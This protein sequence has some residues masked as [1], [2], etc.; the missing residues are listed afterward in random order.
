MFTTHNSHNWIINKIHRK[1]IKF[2]FLII[3]I[4]T[5]HYMAPFAWEWIGGNTHIFRPQQPDVQ[6][7]FKD[8]ETIHFKKTW[9][10]F[11]C[12]V[13][14]WHWSRGVQLKRRWKLQ[15]KYYLW[16]FTLHWNVSQYDKVSHYKPLNRLNP[17]NINQS[18]HFHYEIDGIWDI[19][20]QDLR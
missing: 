2:H 18:W 16:N 11:C 7:G 10:M 12:Y 3:L 9:T 5:K 19:K 4:P 14:L 15:K 13:F 20:L 8:L 1:F 6:F 17:P